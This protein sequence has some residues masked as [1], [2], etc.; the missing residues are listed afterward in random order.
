MQ[1]AAGSGDIPEVPPWLDLLQSSVL[2]RLQHVDVLHVRS[3]HDHCP[4][5]A[6]SQ[7]YRCLELDVVR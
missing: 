4:D 1:F 2:V 3:E 6:E 7:A 5:Y